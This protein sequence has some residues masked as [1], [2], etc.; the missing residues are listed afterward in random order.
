MTKDNSG[1]LFKN[2][3][4]EEGTKQPD[5]KGDIMVGGNVMKASAW[6]NKD[7]NGNHYIGLQ[8]QSM[9]DVAKYSK[10]TSDATTPPEFEKQKATNDLPF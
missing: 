7:K 5:F 4:K 8:F 2:T 3:F 6:I 9:D 10:K 1:N